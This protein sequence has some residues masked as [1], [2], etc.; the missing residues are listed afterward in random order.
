MFLEHAAGMDLFLPYQKTQQMSFKEHDENHQ[1]PADV[2]IVCAILFGE[3]A[4]QL[5][6][7]VDIPVY[8]ANSSIGYIPA[9]NQSGKFLHRNAYRFNELSIGGRPVSP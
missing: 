9:P 4:V 2:G 5:S 3:G 1:N 8:V 7:I 6:G